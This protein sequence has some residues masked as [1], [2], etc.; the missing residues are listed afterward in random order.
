MRRSPLRSRSKK[1]A[2]TYRQ[3]RAPL[4]AQLLAE[5]P[6]CQRCKSRRSSEVH[7]IKSRARGGSIL[8]ENNLAILCHDCHRWITEHPAEATNQG[9][10]AHSWES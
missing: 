2:K 3:H 10:L 5:V 6:T 1:T 4:V 9:W 7:E 8:D